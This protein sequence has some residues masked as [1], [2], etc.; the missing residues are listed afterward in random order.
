MTKERAEELIEVF[1]DA[2]HRVDL[3]ET[4][5]KKCPSVQEILEAIHGY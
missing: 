1:T 5:L 2:D 3:S 4:E